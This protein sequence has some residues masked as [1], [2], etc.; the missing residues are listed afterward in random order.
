MGNVERINSGTMP[1][2]QDDHGSVSFSHDGQ[3]GAKKK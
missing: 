2:I 3:K 1:E